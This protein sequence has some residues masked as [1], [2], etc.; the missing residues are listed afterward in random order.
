MLIPELGRAGS[1]YTR[2]VQPRHP[3]SEKDRPDPG[4][5]F[6]TLL[7]RDKVTRVSSC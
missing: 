7:R 1:R 4:L 2:T 3:V 5:V 6:D